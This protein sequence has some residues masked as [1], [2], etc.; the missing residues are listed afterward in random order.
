MRVR[1]ARELPAMIPEGTRER[2]AAKVGARVPG[3]CWNW[4]GALSGNGYG[5]LFVA[6]AKYRANRLALWLERGLRVPVD[7][8]VRHTCDNRRCVNP[9]HLILGTHSDNMWD[10]VG[11]GRHPAKRKTHCLHG[12]PLSGDNVLLT[13][14]GWRQCR[15][16]ASERKN[17]FKQRRA[18][19]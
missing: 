19:S 17:T 15:A 4:T 14:D 10:M 18:A 9:D 7:Q 6:G 12:H 8:D 2:F 1:L 13:R 3:E 5:Q 16:C 11:R